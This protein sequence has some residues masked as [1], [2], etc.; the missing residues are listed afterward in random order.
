MLAGTS[1]R[2]QANYIDSLF[3]IDLSPPAP[4][5]FHNFPTYDVMF[6]FFGSIFPAKSSM[7]NFVNHTENCCE[8]I[9]LPGFWVILH[10]VTPL[11]GSVTH[12]PSFASKL[13]LSWYISWPIACSFIPSLRSIHMNCPIW[14]FSFKFKLGGNNYYRAVFWCHVWLF[15]SDHFFFLFFYRSWFA[16]DWNGY[17]FIGPFYVHGQYCKPTK[18]RMG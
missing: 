14:N 6:S 1:W 11:F 9:K 7:T 3:C 4:S 8:G 18:R 10:P 17:T 5:P 13:S 16:R 15:I 2:L 12:W